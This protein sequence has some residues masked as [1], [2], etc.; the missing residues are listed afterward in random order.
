M[1]FGCDFRVLQLQ[2]LG[3]DTVSDFN[4]VSCSL[5]SLLW[6]DNALGPVLS[7]AYAWFTRDS[8]AASN[9]ALAAALTRNCAAVAA[10][11]GRTIGS[12]CGR[13]I[14]YG[15]DSVARSNFRGFG[16]RTRKVISLKVRCHRRSKSDTSNAIGFT[17]K[18]KQ[19]LW[20]WNT[21]SYIY[22]G[23]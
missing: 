16:T 6:D 1:T 5:P 22:Y 14:A 7:T 18:Y 10:G 2:L 12:C 15:L 21:K 3:V 4:N 8:Q 23:V 19:I 11:W 9:L 17:R 13:H 20:I